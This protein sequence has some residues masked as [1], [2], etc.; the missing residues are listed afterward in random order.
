MRGT[1]AEL[2][3]QLHRREEPRGR[4]RDLAQRQGAVGHVERGEHV[5]V[6]DDP[7][8]HHG[9]GATPALLR[10]LEDELHPPV[11]VRRAGQELGH[12]EADRH[13]AVVP[14]GV[15][16]TLAVRGEALAGRPVRRLARLRDLRRVHV[17]PEGDRRA[18]APLQHAHDA[19]PR[20]RLGARPYGAPVRLHDLRRRHPARVLRAEALGA[21]ES[22]VA[23]RAEPPRHEAGRAVLQPRRL[24]M[25]MQVTADRGERGGQPLGRVAQGQVSSVIG[26]HRAL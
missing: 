2:D 8:R 20:G 7:R 24:R 26:R 15:H 1:A 25:V 19:R 12:A 17:E 6:V 5:D 21:D 18:G 23:Q 16:Y 13:V 11:P 9:P 22:A 3:V 14:A 10:R 4:Q